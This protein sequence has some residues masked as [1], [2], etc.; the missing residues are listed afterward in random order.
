MT[1]GSG[2]RCLALGSE[3]QVSYDSLLVLPVGEDCCTLARPSLVPDLVSDGV[4]TRER[5]GRGGE[6]LFLSLFFSDEDRGS[7]TPG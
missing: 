7:V 3:D 1:Q 6:R 4:D 5:K 2:K